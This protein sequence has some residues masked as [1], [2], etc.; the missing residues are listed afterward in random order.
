MVSERVVAEAVPDHWKFDTVIV[1]EGQ[2]F[3]PV[4]ADILGLFLREPHD[5]LWLEDP[6]QNLRDQQP[7]V[8]PGFVGYRARANYRTPQTIA[9]VIQ[10]ALPFEFDAVNELPGLG[11]GVTPYDTPGEQPRLVAKVIGELRARGFTHNQIVVLTTQHVVTSGAPRSVLDGPAR[12]GNYHLRRF[13]GGYDLLGN[14]LTTP[15]QITFD[16]VGRFKGQESPAVILVDVDP[17]P[18]DQIRAD[19][20]L[21]AGMTRATVRLELIMRGDNPLNRRFG[22]P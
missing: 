22:G 19:R 10:R 2:D 5:F 14:Q 9:R 1:D 15:G 11:V 7:V 4:W 17:D 18:T 8:L 12:V 13:T 21:F 6:D 3:E 20:L 16:S